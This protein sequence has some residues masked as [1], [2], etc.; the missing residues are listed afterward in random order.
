MKKVLIMGANGYIGRSLTRYLCNMEDEY[1]VVA[2]S[3]NDNHIDARAKLKKYD[4]VRDWKEKQELMDYFEQPDICIYLAWQDGFSHNAESHIKYLPYHWDFMKVMLDNGLKHLVVAG[5]FR[6]YGTF[7]G[8]AK[9]DSFISPDN[10]YTLAKNTIH[11]AIEIYL[12]NSGK[13][14][15]F[16]W[17]R[18]FSVFGEDAY[19]N[20]I[21]SKIL[22]W[23]AEGKT[24]FPCTAGTE[25]YD[26]IHIN[27]L[28]MQIEKII[29]QTKIQGTINCCTGSSTSLKDQ[30]EKFISDHNLKINPIY[31][32]YQR[33]SYDSDEIYGDRTKLNS[34]L[35]VEK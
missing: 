9:E 28:T 7:C 10:Y 18:P 5:T 12:L 27:E 33:R 22:L 34:I 2:S 14:I 29:S 17:L 31:G 25:R 8:A 6:E 3:R 26:F 24:S 20:S 23:E 32:E 30:I 19:N 1:Q 16:Q 4:I 13:D 21:F 11:R 35:G 15:C